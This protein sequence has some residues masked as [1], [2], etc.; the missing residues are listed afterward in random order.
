MPKKHSQ[1]RLL[2]QGARHTLNN[3]KQTTRLHT[4]TRTKCS[5]VRS[6]ECPLKGRETVIENNKQNNE[7]E[8]RGRRGGKGKGRRRGEKSFNITPEAKY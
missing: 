1:V 6:S 5:V 8:D 4:K 7:Q 3:K 2:W